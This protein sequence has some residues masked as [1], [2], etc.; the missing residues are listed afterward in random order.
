MMKMNYL[1]LVL[2]GM[3]ITTAATAFSAELS[4]SARS[5][6]QNYLT[7]NELEERWTGDEPLRQLDSPE[8]RAAYG[9]RQFYFTFK[10]APLPPGAPM[11]ELIER[12]KREMAEYQKQSLRLTVGFDSAQR[13]APFQ[14]ADDF[15]AGLMPVKSDADAK[16]AAAAI[17][18]LIG[19]EQVAP[20]AISANEVAV[21]ATDSAWICSVQ[22]KRGID[23]K[24]V[25]D[26]SGKC[27]SASKRLNY[28]PPT[29]P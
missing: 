4:S 10:A 5:A 24:V 2:G 29:P 28:V 8:L 18:S 12:H 6:F 19:N 26:R 11:P 23:G 7:T 9:D 3:M 14:K 21:T 1:A 27:V 15:N 13:V 25:F 16:I 17:L 22:Q 20:K